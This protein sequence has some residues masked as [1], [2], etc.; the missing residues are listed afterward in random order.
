MAFKHRQV[1]PKYVLVHSIPKRKLLCGC[2]WH[3]FTTGNMS[4][5]SWVEIV[6]KWNTEKVKHTD[7]H[8]WLLFFL[9]RNSLKQH[10][11]RSFRGKSCKIKAHSVQRSNCQSV[12][13]LIFLFLECYKF[14]YRRFVWN[15]P[16][17]ITSVPSRWPLIP[18]VTKPISYTWKPDFCFQCV[19]IIYVLD[20]G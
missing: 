7:T 13:V 4:S 8:V 14:V 10:L 18:E 2:L 11:V 9:R 15:N 19:H 16:D 1:P 17:I 3:V 6:E 5:F 12:K 20:K